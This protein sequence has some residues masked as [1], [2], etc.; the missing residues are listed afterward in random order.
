MIKLNLKAESA[1]LQAIKEFL[2]ENANEFLAEKI[3]NGVY[4]QKDGK[5][6]LNKKDLDIICN[7][8]IARCIIRNVSIRINNSVNLAFH[9]S[10]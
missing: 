1:E 9:R 10:K 8:G 6:L 2:E 4:I 5:R 3:N 7:I